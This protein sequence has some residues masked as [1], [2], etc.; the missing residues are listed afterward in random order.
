MKKLYAFLG[1]FISF[2]AMSSVKNI[3]EGYFDVEVKKTGD[4][5]IKIWVVEQGFNVSSQISREV[6]ERIFDIPIMFGKEIF[7][8]TK[9]APGED[10]QQ[11]VEELILSTYKKDFSKYFPSAIVV[12]EHVSMPNFACQD[13]KK[14]LV[15]TG[16]V[17]KSVYTMEID[18]DVK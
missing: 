12:S 14:M 1:L 10:I 13:S 9:L 2:Q 5:I 7:K 18:F 16:M 3:S 8:Q 15:R 4:T 6:R 17:C 11:A